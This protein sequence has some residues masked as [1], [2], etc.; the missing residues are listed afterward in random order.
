MNAPSARLAQSSVVHVLFAFLAMGGWAWFANRMHPPAAAIVAAFVQGFLSGC[1]TLV[2]KTAIEFLVK[3][4]SGVAALV[5]PPLAAFLT[6][7]VVLSMI[8]MLA[9]TPEILTTIALPLTV[10]TTYAFAYTYSLWRSGK[11]A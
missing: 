6:S 4:L 5:I 8:H 10:S 7:L 1:I 11:D 3:R 9:G 2:L